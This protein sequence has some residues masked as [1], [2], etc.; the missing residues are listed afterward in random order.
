MISYGYFLYRAGVLGESA[1]NHL[2]SVVFKAFFPILIF[3]NIYKIKINELLDIKLLSFALLFEIALLTASVLIVPRIIKDNSKGGV[4]AQ[5]IFRSNFVLFGLSLASSV[6]GPDNI[7]SASM[8]VAIMVPIFYVFSIATLEIFRGGCFNFKS[9]IKSVLKN[10]IIW[11][12]AAGSVICVSGISLPPFLQ[13]V[14]S[15][16]GSAANP[17]A[18]L[19][20]GGTMRFCASRENLRI[21]S[22]S[23][24]LRLIL[25][26]LLGITLGVLLG[27]R[28]IELFTIMVMTAAPVAVSSYTLAQQMGGDGELACQMVVFSSAIS[29]ATI[30]LWIFALKTVGLI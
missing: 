9:I 25:V 15:D 21:L 14:I 24:M 10:Q 16:L 17:L 26:P 20:M 22:A 3:K 8:V 13:S 1:V 30:F 12:A 7:G 2:N 11:G 4:L 18:L 29:L 6:Y 19:A 23:L 28:N 27:F 5:S